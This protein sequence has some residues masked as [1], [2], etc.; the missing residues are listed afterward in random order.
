MRR[1]T[2]WIEVAALALGIALAGV[3]LLDVAGLMVFPTV[4]R[5]K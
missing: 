4:Y 5:N 1:V 3:A 2:S